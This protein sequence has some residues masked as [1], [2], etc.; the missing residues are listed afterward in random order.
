MHHIHLFIQG[1]SDPRYDQ[2][3]L[4]ITKKHDIDITEKHGNDTASVY[5]AQ[6]LF[7][8]MRKDSNLQCEMP[9]LHHALLVF[10]EPLKHATWIHDIRMNVQ[11]NFKIKIVQ[12]SFS[13]ELHTCESEQLK[14]REEGR[15]HDFLHEIITHYN[16][17]QVNA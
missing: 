16:S 3:V 14:Q 5:T 8:K 12:M 6:D 1:E 11:E 2:T 15:R 9:F 10:K 7:K 4:T 17:N 13:H